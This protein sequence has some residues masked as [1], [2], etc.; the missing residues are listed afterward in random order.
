MT[1]TAQDMLILASAIL[2]CDAIGASQTAHFYDLLDIL[3]QDPVLYR[4]TMETLAEREEANAAAV[5]PLKPLF[6]FEA[7]S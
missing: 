2:A 7:V 4:M 6:T 1:S 5:S 3:S